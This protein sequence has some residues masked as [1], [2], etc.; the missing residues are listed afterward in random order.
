MIVRVNSA[1]PDSWETA[2]AT[3]TVDATRADQLYTVSCDGAEGSYV[4]VRL[5]EHNLP[6]LPP[7]TLL[8]YL[9]LAPPFPRGGAHPR[10]RHA[11]HASLAT[12]SKHAHAWGAN[13][14]RFANG[15]V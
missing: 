11:A 1:G 10:H 13:R 5:L 8:K 6:C 9:R 4:T 12:T 7:C 15:D 3:I 2:C 14:R